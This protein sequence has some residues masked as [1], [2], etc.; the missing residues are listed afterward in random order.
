MDEAVQAFLDHLSVE[1]GVSPNTIA[2]YGRDLSQFVQFAAKQGVTSANDLTEPLLISFMNH[3]R[4][5]GISARSVSRKL[6]AI[7]T[8]AKFAFRDG[9]L[10]NDF[11]ANTS[12]LRIA[13][14]LPS[15]LTIEEVEKIGRA[16]V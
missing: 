4:K 13:K 11:T 9:Y 3:L 14:K 15:T 16:H 5:S 6:S 10:H 12:G 7:K 1:R 8:F 2:A